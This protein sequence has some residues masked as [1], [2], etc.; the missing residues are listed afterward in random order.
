[1]RPYSAAATGWTARARQ[2]IKGQSAEFSIRKAIDDYWDEVMTLSAWLGQQFRP[3]HRDE[4]DEYHRLLDE[5][6]AGGSGAPEAPP[7]RP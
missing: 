4:F 3:L 5:F 2:Y 1:V 6:L 7:G